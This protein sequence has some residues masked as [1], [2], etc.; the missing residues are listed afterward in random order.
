MAEDSPL[1]NLLLRQKEA[2]AKSSGEREAMELMG[3][4][5]AS[6]PAEWDR[7]LACLNRAIKA[8]NDDFSAVGFPN[9]FRFESRSQP[10][11][12]NVAYGVV[13]HRD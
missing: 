13:A 6:V 1:R 5:A 2:E 10:G 7:A 12:G 9:G 3:T 11:S 4:H 8:A